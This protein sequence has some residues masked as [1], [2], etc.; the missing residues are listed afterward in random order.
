MMKVMMSE[1][2]R[3]KLGKAETVREEYELF[4]HRKMQCLHIHT[5]TRIRKNTHTH[6]VLCMC[7]LLSNCHF[8][9]VLF[10]LGI[11]TET[12]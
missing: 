6:T 10:M 4:G 2:L 11:P 3:T 9:F 5:R 12:I 8:I 7:E 1:E